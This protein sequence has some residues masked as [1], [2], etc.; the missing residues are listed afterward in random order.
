MD[1]IYDNLN[2]IPPNPS[3]LPHSP[4]LVAAIMHTIDTAA[5]IDE[6]KK[7]LASDPTWHEALGREAGNR[8]K[9]WSQLDDFIL[10]HDQIYVPPSLCPKILFQYHDSPLA[11]HPGHAK[12]IE[13]IA[14]DYSWPGMTYDTC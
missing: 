6:F 12:T 14:H 5:P 1:L 13:L 11:G 7:A 3:S 4:T 2:S 9:N 10:F 8:H